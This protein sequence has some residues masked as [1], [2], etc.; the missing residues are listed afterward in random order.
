[1]R[2]ALGLFERTIGPDH[3]RVYWVLGFLCGAY[4]DTGRHDDAITCSDRR[5][6][7]LRDCLTRGDSPNLKADALDTEAGR[8]EGDGRVRE[9]RELFRAALK[10]RE[11]IYGPHNNVVG[12][13][14]FQIAR[15][16]QLLGEYDEARRMYELARQSW[17]GAGLWSKQ[18]YEPILTGLSSIHED[19]GEY[20]EARRLRRAAIESQPTLHDEVPNP[21]VGPRLVDYAR[22]L[23][24]AGSTDEAFAAA[25]E[26]E[27]II[28]PHL[29]LT[30][31][32]LS[33]REGLRYAAT[34]ASGLDVALSVAANADQ[35]A[36][37]AAAFE[38]LVRARALVL[39]EIANRQQLA[40]GTGDPDAAELAGQLMAVRGRLADLLVRGPGSEDAD[41]YRQAVDRTRAAKEAI[42]RQL[43]QLSLAFR[44]GQAADGV[45]L[46]GVQHALHEG[47][48]LVSFARFLQFQPRTE[49]GPILLPAADEVYL[50]FV[51]RPGRCTAVPL[52]PARAIDE[53]ISE[54]RACLE[55]AATA[56][57]VGRSEGVYRGAARQL[58]VLIWDPIAAS[59]D[60][61]KRVFVV[62]DG[63][64]NLV[65]FAALP[66]DDSGYLME[67]GPRIH[68]LAAERDLVDPERRSEGRGVLAL[69]APAFDDPLQ[70]AQLR[71]VGDQPPL[72]KGLELARR[73]TFRGTRSV[74]GDFR[75]IRFDPLSA[76]AREVEE[77]SGVWLQRTGVVGPPIGRNRQW[78]RHHDSHRARS[79]RRPP[80][81][82]SH[83]ATGCSTPQHTASFSGRPARRRSTG[84]PASA[85]MACQMT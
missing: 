56:G 42:E 10:I 6:E 52:G 37:A 55:D 85:S 76:A 19:L 40:W 70:F 7:I 48:A 77:L 3:Q 18:P 4:W 1:M 47:D 80:S 31:P 16:S 84:P 5:S 79:E 33:E 67:Y 43:A 61:S 57:S 32:G 2:P 44:R 27:R 30:I 50:A 23:M 74:C 24:R 62:P 28:R 68:Y 72:E 35:P 51:V 34:W 8:L 29:R 45:D 58:R 53:Q 82:S 59:L 60:G 39:D 21:G 54:V 22:F 38:T 69:G 64:L 20:E 65:H 78:H 13:T 63:E 75:T 11:D 71:T 9:A 81:S 49:A 12:W 17:E 15:T 83:Q 46:T 73:E 25:L 14:R 41:R 26:A 36:V 66:A